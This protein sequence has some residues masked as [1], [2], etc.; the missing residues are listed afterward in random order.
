M[1]QVDHAN[2]AGMSCRFLAG[3][4]YGIGVIEVACLPLFHSSDS[5]EISVEVTFIVV[6]LRL[7]NDVESSTFQSENP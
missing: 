5:N 7:S 6:I 4:Q 1:M 3:V 2:D